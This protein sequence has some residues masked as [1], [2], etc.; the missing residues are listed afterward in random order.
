MVNRINLVV[1]RMPSIQ[2]CLKKVPSS[3]PIHTQ[4]SNPLFYIIFGLTAFKKNRMSSIQFDKILQ[5]SSQMKY[6]FAEI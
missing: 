6:F 4:S 2:N 3:N 5:H 1:L